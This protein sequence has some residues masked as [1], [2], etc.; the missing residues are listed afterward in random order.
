MAVVG[1]LLSNHRFACALGGASAAQ[2]LLRFKLSLAE[3]VSEE[4]V[5]RGVRSRSFQAHHPGGTGNI[6]T[7]VFVWHNRFPPVSHTQK[8]SSGRQ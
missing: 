4:W 6:L 5:R 8:R 1:A 3:N 2:Y 7:T